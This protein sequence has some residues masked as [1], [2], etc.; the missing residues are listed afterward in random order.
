VA[1][2]RSDAV[3]AERRAEIEAR[4][5]CLAPQAEWLE[6][7]HRPRGLLSTSGQRTDL[8]S[9][10]GQSLAAF[11]GIGNPAGF[12][13]TL[14]A[15]GLD[16]AEFMELPDHCAYDERT[17][18]RLNGWLE[19]LPQAAVAVCTQKDLVKIPHERLAG[20]ALWAVEIELA[21]VRGEEELRARL[22]EIASRIPT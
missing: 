5:N 9:L 12:R 13:H 16:A 22:E 11:C 3:P 4:V 8:A 2:S 1:L 7:T 19:S 14:A 17:I 18:S 6:L 10:R 20:R 15:A 21:I